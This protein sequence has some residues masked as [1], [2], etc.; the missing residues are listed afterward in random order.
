ML[1]P[2]TSLLQVVEIGDARALSMDG[3]NWQIQYLV[4]E[5]PQAGPGD[6]ANPG[7]RYTLLGTI[8]HGELKTRPRFGL[9][10]TEEVSRDIDEIA[11][12]VRAAVLPFAAID[13][14]EYWLLD[15]H[16]QQPLA[17]LQ[18]CISED[19]MSASIE[20]MAAYRVRPEW[21]AMPAAQLKI[22][23]DEDAGGHYVPPVNHRLQTLIGDRA[24]FYPK[25]RW[26][27]RGQHDSEDFP[28]CLVSE[29]WQR[30]QDRELCQRYIR[31][32]APRLLMLQDL[33]RAE[34]QRLERAASENAI[35]VERF[36]SLYP[37]IIDEKLIT[38]LRVEAKM[39]RAAESGRA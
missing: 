13:R 26:F 23:D 25:A 5:K 15:E 14:Y 12:L 30:E 10:D 20:E 6:G 29:S 24:G 21:Q 31:R 19:E 16:G 38:A 11:E 39:R 28:C 22:E 34:R 33:P 37:E 4:N 18:S 17:L 1:S 7:E 27:E 35:D 32:L 36:H 8:E 9:L 3:G 2:Y